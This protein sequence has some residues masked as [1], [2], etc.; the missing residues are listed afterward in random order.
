MRDFPRLFQTQEEVLSRYFDAYKVTFVPLDPAHS[1]MGVVGTEFYVISDNGDGR[2][3]SE[4]V[5]VYAIEDGC[6]PLLRN[7]SDGQTVIATALG[8]MPGTS[9]P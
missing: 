2:G 4:R 7:W 3:T 8:K 5:I 9:T 1:D 6:E